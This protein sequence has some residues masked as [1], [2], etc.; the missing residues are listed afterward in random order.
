[1]SSDV[2][3]AYL[4]PHK[5]FALKTFFNV[6]SSVVDE[7]LYFFKNTIP[8]RYDF[9]LNFFRLEFLNGLKGF[10]SCFVG[11]ANFDNF[12]TTVVFTKNSK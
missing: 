12:Y 2:L 10:G 5:F 9:W 6:V 3:S 4:P 7:L 1:M 8:D 11:L